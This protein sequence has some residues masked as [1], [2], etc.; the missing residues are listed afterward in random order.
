[1]TLTRAAFGVQGNRFNGVL[2]WV[3]SVSFEALNTVFGV[4][5]VAALL[6]I[7][8]WTDATLPGGAHRVKDAV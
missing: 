8:G 1:M 4:F 6:P 2:A 5:A 7:L 3:T